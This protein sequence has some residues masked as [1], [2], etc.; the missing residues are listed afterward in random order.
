MSLNNKQYDDMVAKMI[1]EIH[2]ERH[3]APPIVGDEDGGCDDED[4]QSGT[5]SD[6]SSGKSII[7]NKGREVT[8]TVH[9]FL[10]LFTLRFLILDT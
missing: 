8:C 6:A 2:E 9:I 1:N 3:P 5:E 4:S 7:I 10:S